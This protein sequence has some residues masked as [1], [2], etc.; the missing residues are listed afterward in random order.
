MSQLNIVYNFY[1][2]PV[3]T[4]VMEY[5]Y[6]TYSSFILWIHNYTIAIQTASRSGQSDY[7][8]MH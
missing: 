8:D 3:R 1:I 5:V 2:I 4:L 7:Q 6:Y